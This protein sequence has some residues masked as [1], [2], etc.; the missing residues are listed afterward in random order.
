M[1]LCRRGLHADANRLL[2]RYL[3]SFED[4]L[5]QIEGLALLPLFL[6][7]RAA[8]R[9]KV[10]AIQLRLDPENPTLRD[11]AIV[12]FT[13]SIRF[14]TPVPPQLIA[15]GGLSGTGKTTLAAVIAPALGRAPG[16]LHLRSDIERKRLFA[17][18]ETTRLP[19]HAYRPD[20]TT[21]V[22]RR[23]HKLAETALH[24]G[25][26]VIVDATHQQPSEREAIA[27]LASRAGVSFLGLWLEAP[28]ELLTQR[29]TDR[30]GDASDATA[31]VV[32]TQAS[33]TI[34][35]LTWQRIDAS[36][37]LEV[38]KAK[39]LRLAQHSNAQTPADRT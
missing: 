36:Q 17:V 13:A 15:I 30:R 33:E 19:A 32:M 1:D 20:I 7:L 27:A 24:A 39:A 28:V 5:P 31:A 4:E 12:Y 10:I 8:I 16:A 9:A 37:P 22:Y 18:G 23:L 2:N 29:V 26:T 35:N 14:L 25:Q 34:E 21:A 3:S 38:S 6:S 11:E